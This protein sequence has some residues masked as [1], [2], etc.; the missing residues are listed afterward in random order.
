[1][2]V[3]YQQKILSETC[4]EYLKFYR[5]MKNVPNI[6]DFW[7]APAPPTAQ[8]IMVCICFHFELHIVMLLMQIFAIL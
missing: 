5:F 3:N 7:H 1:M 8:E 2:C 6:Q 4:V